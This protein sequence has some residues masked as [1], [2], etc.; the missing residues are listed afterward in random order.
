MNAREAVGGAGPR[1][2]PPV[3]ASSDTCVLEESSEEKREG[4]DAFFGLA[5]HGV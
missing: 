1:E 3:K 5:W 2:M 4:L